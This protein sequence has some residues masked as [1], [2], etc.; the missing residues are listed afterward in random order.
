MASNK[1]AESGA[2]PGKLKD[3]EQE[4]K[5]EIGELKR[6]L[7]SLACGMI[8]TRVLTKEPKVRCIYIYIYIYTCI[9]CTDILQ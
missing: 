1:L 7:Q 6:T 2:E 5:I 3:L 9:N 4:T 8:G